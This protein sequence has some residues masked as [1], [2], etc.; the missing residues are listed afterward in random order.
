M[1]VEQLVAENDLMTIAVDYLDES[2]RL[3][4]AKVVNARTRIRPQKVREANQ[5]YQIS[6]PL[7][8]SANAETSITQQP[9]TA[10]ATA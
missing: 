1:V 7:V 10:K 8:A 3:F 9:K 4:L 2:H 5:L 6:D